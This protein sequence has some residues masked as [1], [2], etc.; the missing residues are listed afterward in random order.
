MQRS[1]DV[2]PK[3]KDAL[4][5][6]SQS[7]SGTETPPNG[8]TAHNT[9][10]EA[11]LFMGVAIPVNMET[12]MGKVRC[13][14]SLPPEV[15]ASPQALLNA[16]KHIADMGLPIDAYQPKHE[17]GWNQNGSGGGWRGGNG[18]RNGNGYNGGGYRRGGW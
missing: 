1:Q 5:I 17:N 18:Y 13:Y 14:L 16:I 12:P 10:P 6:L 4:E 3:L 2:N 7:L 9:Q 8:W 11:S 15:A